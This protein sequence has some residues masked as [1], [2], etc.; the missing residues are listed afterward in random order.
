MVTLKFLAIFLVELLRLYLAFWITFV[1]QFVK[2]DSHPLLG[3]PSKDCL[4]DHLF[5]H[6]SVFFNNLAISLPK[7]PEGRKIAT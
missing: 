7:W 5:T 1:A 6:R 3:L 2:T 4:F